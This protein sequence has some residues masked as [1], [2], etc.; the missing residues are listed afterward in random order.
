VLC[1]PQTNGGLL[2]CLRPDEKD[3]V[4]ATLIANGCGA[5]IIGRVD[6]RRVDGTLVEAI[7]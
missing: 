1:D 7:R 2:I 6:E 4:L 3:E 5:R